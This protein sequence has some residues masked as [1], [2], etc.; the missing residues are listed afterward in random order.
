MKLP[1][2]GRLFS[3]Q[4]TDNQTIYPDMA[5]PVVG[6]GSGS[7][8]KSAVLICLVLVVTVIAG[9]VL[10]MFIT[11]QDESK[12]TTEAKNQAQREAQPFI[13]RFDSVHSF[14]QFKGAW[15]YAVNGGV[16][17]IAD[18]KVGYFSN[19]QGIPQGT[20]TD[21]VVY[22][23]RLWLTTQH[24]IATLDKEGKTFVSEKVTDNTNE[25]SNGR[26]FLDDKAGKLYLSTFDKLYS[27]DNKTNKWAEVTGPANVFSLASN[28][29]HTALYASQPGWPIWVYDKKAD[30]WKQNSPAIEQQSGTVVRVDK[31]IFLIGRT[32]GY[33]SCDSAGK[34]VA[35]SAFRL[36]ERGAWQPVV[37][38]NKDKDRAELTV[39]RSPTGSVRLKSAPCGSETAKTYGLSYDGTLKL[40]EARDA[41]DDQ[42][43]SLENIADQNTLIGEIKKA[44]GLQPSMHVWDVDGKGN[45]IFSYGD[46]YSGNSV[47]NEPYIGIAA[48]NILSKAKLIAMPVLKGRYNVPILCGTGADRKLAY[49]FS[50]EVHIAPGSSHG[51]P[52]GTWASARL[53]IAD[54][55]DTTLKQVVDLVDD[56]AAPVFACDD[57]QVTWLGKTHVKM[58]DRT[59]NAVTRFG[60]PVGTDLRYSNT[61]AAATPMGSL[62]FGLAATQPN[63]GSLLLFD[64]QQGKYGSVA[65]NVNIGR[66]SSATDNEV[67]STSEVQKAPSQ[68][69]YNR[70]GQTIITFDAVGP[71]ARAEDKNAYIE[72]ENQVTA[73]IYT[74][75]P[76]SL[77]IHKRD[78]PA[79]QLAVENSGFT[80]R[81]SAEDPVLNLPLYPTIVYDQGRSTVWLNDAMFGINAL[82]IKQ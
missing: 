34:V 27:Y 16:I 33:T 35:T 68:V 48:G 14:A 28:E 67:V 23:D 21:L 7:R 26:L 46:E 2:F 38:F 51:S 52:D 12:S 11:N 47:A 20:P 66:L 41:S 29:T 76:F 13:P 79:Q 4:P 53:Y 71:V 60:Q 70:K 36:D 43:M 58:M 10:F 3:K 74:F 77:A 17:K 9:I 78:V 24:G 81:Y 72:L 80:A 75:K 19:A 64:A 30:T 73:A 25:L 62:W 18:D 82:T 63:A 31:D 57:K 8:K 54:E 37:D 15:W 59:T 44:T 32:A 69:V 22:N 6:T 45:V 61:A 50:G 39:L 40:V 49:I 5:E 42:R 55:N 65:Q 1:L 56:V